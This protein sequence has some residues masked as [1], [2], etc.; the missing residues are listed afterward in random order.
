MYS[1]WLLVAD[2]LEA[3]PTLAFDMNQILFINFFVTFGM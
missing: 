2:K 1:V 3:I